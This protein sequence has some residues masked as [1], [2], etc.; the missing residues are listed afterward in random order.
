[1]PAQTTEL[2]LEEAQRI[3]DHHA[4]IKRSPRGGARW[5]ATDEEAAEAR[6]LYKKA[7]SIVYYSTRPYP[8]KLLTP[9]R[10]ARMAARGRATKV[11]VDAATA[12]FYGHVATAEAIVCFWCRQ[13]VPKADRTVDHFRPLAKGGEHQ[14]KNLVAACHRCNSLKRDLWAHDFIAMIVR[15][16][17]PI[18]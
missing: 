11:K 4:L 15:G 8:P 10:R 9:R 14:A 2:T 18:K 3:L 16:R 5:Y 7:H 1:M 17:L 6:R 13:E 12:A